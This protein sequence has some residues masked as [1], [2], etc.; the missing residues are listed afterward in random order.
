MTLEPKESESLGFLHKV[1]LQG[2]VILNAE[3]D[4]HSAPAVL[5]YSVDEESIGIV[6]CVV[7]EVGFLDCSFLHFLNAA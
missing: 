7:E 4:V 5:L 1:I 2:L 6:D 3:D